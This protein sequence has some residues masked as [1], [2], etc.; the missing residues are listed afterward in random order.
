[1]CYQSQMYFKATALSWRT[2]RPVSVS[3]QDQVWF[4][5][6][7]QRIN[8][9]SKSWRLGLVQIRNWTL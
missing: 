9:C 6:S 5:F 2:A 1:M 3:D 8:S 7:I 4:A